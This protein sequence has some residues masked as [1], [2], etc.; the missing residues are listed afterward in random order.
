MK[1]EPGSPMST[2]YVIRGLL[3]LVVV[4]LL[5]GATIPVVNAISHFLK[6]VDVVRYLR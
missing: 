5:S 1:L 6:A 3:L 2:T 4:A